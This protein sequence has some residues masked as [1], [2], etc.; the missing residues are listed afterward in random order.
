MLTTKMG[1]MN[2]A[3]MIKKIEKEIK[4]LTKDFPLS[5]EGLVLFK[6]TTPNV[7][8]IFNEADLLVVGYQY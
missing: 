5:L 8:Q 7:F 1:N 6:S 3:I 2:K 4:S